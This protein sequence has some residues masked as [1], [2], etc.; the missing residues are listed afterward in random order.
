M[1]EPVQRWRLRFA[2]DAVPSDAVG[3]VAADAWLDALVMSG[4]P[5]AGLEPGGPGRPRFALGA[6]LPAVCEGRAEL[7]DLWLL[8][9]RPAWAIREALGSRMPPGHR[10]GDA[11]DVWLGAPALS[12]QI[13][14]AVWLVALAGP[15]LDRAALAAAAGRLLAATTLPRVRARAGGDR[16]YDLRPL[17]ADI[18][19]AAPDASGSTPLRITT[20]LD[21]AL[22]SGRPEEV[23]AALADELGRPLEIKSIVRIELVV[24]DPRRVAPPARPVGP[25]RR[26]RR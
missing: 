14:A 12:G 24:A 22:G 26:P 17:L 16:A 21:P 9:R 11:E 2:R 8:E 3:R 20:R 10:Y 18:G 4:L 23:V 25:G 6:P 1:A 13:V 7:A 15:A 19:P 5:V